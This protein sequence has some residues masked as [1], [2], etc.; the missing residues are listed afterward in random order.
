MPGYIIPSDLDRIRRF[1]ATDELLMDW[2]MAFL[3]AS[4]GAVVMAQ[5]RLHR[6]RTLVPA[7]GPTG[8]CVHLAADHRRTI[9]SVAPYGCALFDS[10]MRPREAD[11]RS[12][13]G[14]QSIA[15]P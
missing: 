2:A 7:R 5:G 14:L 9:H 4:P 6:I 3:R 1:L 8:A 11:L 10:H 15:D 13:H 12:R